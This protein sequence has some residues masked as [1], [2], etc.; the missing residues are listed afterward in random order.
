MHMHTQVL[1]T[2]HMATKLQLAVSLWTNNRLGLAWRQW[3]GV[4]ARRRQLRI[5]ATTVAA[6]WMHR[7][8]SA[9]WQRWVQVVQVRLLCGLCVP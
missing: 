3:R 2:W 7:G 6:R 8:L 1:H 9:A 4:T 5:S